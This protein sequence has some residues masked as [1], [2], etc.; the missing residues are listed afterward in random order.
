MFKSKGRLLKVE[1]SSALKASL[2]LAL[3]SSTAYV[4]AN[5]SAYDVKYQ[6]SSS[7]DTAKTT[8]DEEK[9][10][11]EAWRLT[12]TEWQ[13]YKD[14][15]AGRRGTW[16]P[17]L[18]PV[19]ALG[20]HAET[21][22]ERTRYAELWVEIEYERVEK[23]LAFEQAKTEAAKRLYPDLPAIENSGFKRDFELKKAARRSERLVLFT[24]LDCESCSTE[25]PDLYRSL[26]NKGR[27]DIYV[28]DANPDQIQLWAARHKIPP[29]KVQSG[30][31]TLNQARN[32]DMISLGA[33]GSEPQLYRID[34]NGQAEE[35]SL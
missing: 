14:I 31:I 26:G 5:T 10:Q 6:S 4:G 9:T 3:I 34:A 27:L 12:D 19:T 30:V 25:L 18:D 15:M 35:I 21:E 20:V 23:E 16:S 33:Y 13:K 1:Y 11:A 8:S 2:F 24:D 22:E 29:A 28:R 7:S 17:D 32:S